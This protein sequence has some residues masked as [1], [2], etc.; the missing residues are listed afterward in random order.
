M[1]YTRSRFRVESLSLSLFA[2]SSRPI[3]LSPIS[4]F[5]PQ[6]R[7]S[8]QKGFTIRRWFRRI[9]IS[10][11]RNVG[12]GNPLQPRVATSF[13]PSFSCFLGSIPFWCFRR[14]RYEFH[15]VFRTLHIPRCASRFR[16][17]T[18]SEKVITLSRVPI[19]NVTFVDQ[20][21]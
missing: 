12:S 11:I 10:G 14:N 20:R 9:C 21:G 1:H 5:P 16:R 2:G 4:P 3:S 17:R 18:I 19:G 7:R 8:L 6:Y 13:S 15:V